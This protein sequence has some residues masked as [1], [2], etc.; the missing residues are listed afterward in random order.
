[1][2]SP[3]EAHPSD[4]TLEQYA[5]GRLP[6]EQTAELEQH[7]LICP[8]CQDRLA[9]T[10]AFIQAT[11][12]AA[13]NFLMLP[14]SRWTLIG[15]RLARWAELPAPAWAAAA[16]VLL[17]LLIL[18]PR[19]LLPPTQPGA[20]ALT[21]LL[22]ATRGA[23]ALAFTSAPAGRPL[24]LTWDAAG[25]PE[26]A[27]CRIEVLD[28]RG[29]LLRREELRGPAASAGLRLPGLSRGSYWIRLYALPPGQGLLREFGLRVE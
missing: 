13:H 21:I 24:R 4:Q 28:V 27:C 18:L 3:E 8:G 9:E 22:S 2:P 1:M 10:D 25:L 19:W 17:A 16:A 29:G 7:L 14:P 5:L 11:R 12:Q 6:E 20:P 26:G 15:A 23:E